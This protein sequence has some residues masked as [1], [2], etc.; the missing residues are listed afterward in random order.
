MP[1]KKKSKKK[2]ETS[3][4]EEFEQEILGEEESVEI[5]PSVKT[6]GSDISELPGVGPKTAEKLIAAGL[7][8]I[9]SIAV[10]SPAELAAAADIGKAT[11]QKLIVAARTK[12]EFGFKPANLLYKQRL[13]VGKVSTGSENLDALLGGGVE[14]QAI[15]E[16]FGEFRTGKT[17]IAHQ[18]AVNV[19][20]PKA[21]GGLNGG[22]IYIDSEGT[23][24]PERIVQMATAIGADPEKLLANIQ[25]ARVYNSDHQIFVAE[26]AQEII[27]ENNIKLIVIDSVTS[28]FRAEYIGRENLPTRQGK[29]NKHLHSLQRMAD[30]YSCVVFITN[31]AMANPAAFFGDPTR[32]VGG[33][34]LAH[35]PQTRLYLKKSKDIRRIA[36]LID[37]PNL[38]EGECIF[39]IQLEGIRD[40]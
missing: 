11:A 10:A 7:K 39:T 26:K 30:I 4:D 35:V 2:E 18:L 15:T 21:K 40:P 13:Q 3:V 8:T 9:V 28:H 20:L 23:F 25:V 14:A 24:R 31:Q 34:V 38:P 22:V 12:A 36:K 37:S 1:A 17:Q 5:E 27:V 16:V 29:L 33:H 19:Q 32:A 6:E